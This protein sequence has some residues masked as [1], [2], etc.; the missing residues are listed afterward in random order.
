V[1]VF[2]NDDDN[3]Q[4]SL[5][6]KTCGKSRGK[7]HLKRKALSLGKQTYHHHRRHH[8]DIYSAPITK[9]T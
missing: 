5:R 2:L 6:H 9:C 7:E 1:Y 4:K 3:E 8:I